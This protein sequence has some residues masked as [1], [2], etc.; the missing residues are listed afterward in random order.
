MRID[1]PN[2]KG[3]QESE[4]TKTTDVSLWHNL[5]IPLKS[6]S[7]NKKKAFYR[8]FALLLKSGVDFH[9]ALQLLT[10]QE[11]NKYI[12]DIYQELL[13][14]IVKGRPL[15]QAMKNNKEFTDYEI[16]SVK[17]GEEIRK[18]PEILDELQTY[19]DR[20]IKIKRQ[21][22]SILAYPSFVL[23]LTLGIL[24]F[25]LNYVVPMF[26]NIFK[27]FG[28]ELPQITQYVVAISEHFNKALLILLIIIGLVVI[29]HHNL[30]KR[31]TYQ[32][33]LGNVILRL[34]VL[35]RHVKRIALTKFC[36]SMALLLTAKTSL[37]E[38]LELSA[39]LIN[40]YPLQQEVL[41][42][43]AKLIKGMTL[44]ESLSDSLFDAKIKTMITIGEEVN[45]LD[46][47][48]DKISQQLNEEIEYATKMLSSILEPLMILIIAVVVG[49]ILIAMYYPM[50][51]L[52]N[53]IGN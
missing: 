41:Q 7:N 36:Q 9:K 13:E 47:M 21:I 48:F 3:K 18:L 39:S 49:F 16:F 14:Q 35:G 32:S 1:I 50:F 46:K 2:H 25:M 37:T 4:K 15:Y 6:F 52:S 28:S 40:F 26:S 29:I 8:D 5:L 10:T 33:F 22:T 44:N 19:F 42:S 45:E 51:S 43:R 27:Q 17:A 11:K 24:Y 20:K 12:K 38:A 23:T 30:K 53:V 31:D 34:P